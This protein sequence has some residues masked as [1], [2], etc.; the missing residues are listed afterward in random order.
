MIP[1]LTLCSVTKYATQNISLW[2]KYYF[3]VKA[4]KTVG[5]RGVLW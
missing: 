3:E 5:P 1:L 4:L 2:H